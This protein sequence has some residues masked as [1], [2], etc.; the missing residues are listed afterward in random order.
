MALSNYYTPVSEIICQPSCVHG[1]CNFATQN[2]DCSAGYTGEACQDGRQTYYS[3]DTV[4]LLISMPPQTYKSVKQ[5]ME[6][7]TRSALILLVAT[8]AHVEM[9][10]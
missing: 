5:T 9:D 3:L 1:Q 8:V 2:C 6:T 10:F 7:A 4:I